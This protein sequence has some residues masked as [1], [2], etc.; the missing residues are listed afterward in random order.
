[1]SRVRIPRGATRVVVAC[2]GGTDSL[3]LL[4]LC[5]AAGHEV[6]AVHVDHGLR[7]GSEREFALVRYAAERLGASAVGVSVAVAPGPGLEARARTARLAA[8]EEQRARLDGEVVLLAHTSDDQAET[9]LLNL[10]RGAATAGL[11]GIP[12]ERDRLAHPILALT[13]S[14]TAEICARLKLEPVRDPMN[15]DVAFRRVWL[16]REVIPLLESGTGG[17]LREV[18]ARQ[19]DVLHEESALLDERADEALM[20]AGWTPGAA[21]LACAALA[22]ERIG[23]ARRMVRRWLGPPPP[24]LAEVDAVLAVA[25][26][27]RAAAALPGGLRVERSHGRLHQVRREEGVSRP[28]TVPVPGFA[29]AHGWQLD[30][31]IERAAPVAWPDGRYTCVLDADEV[32]DRAVVRVAMGGERFVPLGLEGSKSIRSAL[33]EAGIPRGA[34]ATH[35]VVATTAG[36][37]LWI[38]G[39]RVG[40]NARVTSHTRRYLWMRIASSG[41]ERP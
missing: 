23:I 8:L 11:A 5:T 17:D 7:P 39:Y 35:P 6:I 26:G 30:T 34:R 24:S 18:L 16:R 21:S 37:P 27:E 12:P 36:I 10:L 4:A 20:A 38:V 41:Q 25:K 28:F 29:A 2:S 13:R 9:V 19:A 40:A 31:W 14:D 15:D 32:G 22:E 1:M 33:A 3:A